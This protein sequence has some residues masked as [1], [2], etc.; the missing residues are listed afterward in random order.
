MRYLIAILLFVTIPF[1]SQ[2]QTIDT[3]NSEI[4]KL[5]SREQSLKH[6]LDSLSTLIR[7]VRWQIVQRRNELDGIQ[8]EQKKE[9]M[10]SEGFTAKVVSNMYSIKD[11]PS[12]VAEKIADLSKG[13]EVIVYD[14]YQEPYLKINFNGQEGYISY[15]ALEESELLN[16]VTGKTK[17]LKAE[18]PRLPKLIREFGETTARRII[19]KEIWIGMTDKMARESIGRPNDINR[20]TSVYGVSEQWVYPNG[21]Y[22]YF[23]D[24]IL[25]T[26]QD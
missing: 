1:Y 16:E 23:E 25:T 7:D 11:E 13:D 22:L 6:Q 20:T 5:E 3:L 21:R 14:F 24:G 4:E 19:K 17:R 26:I 12:V 18:D 15:G 10:L 8:E 9:Q 2:S